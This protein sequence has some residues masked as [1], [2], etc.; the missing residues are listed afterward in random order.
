M[1]SRFPSDRRNKTRPSTL[2]FVQRI[3]IHSALLPNIVK[4]EKNYFLY[5]THL[6]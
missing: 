2:Q 3:P 4:I 5:K 1:Y 6:A